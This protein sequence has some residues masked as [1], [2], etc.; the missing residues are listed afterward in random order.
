MLVAHPTARVRVVGYADA[1]G[2]EGANANL[3]LARARAV[4]TALTAT[5]VPANRI[6]AASG[7]EA[8]PE[9]SN[10]TAPG[11]SE[12]RRTELVLLSR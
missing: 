10:A 5:G 1:R 7:G 6:E 3:G 2:A 12:N 8:N 11:Q 4:A 9:A